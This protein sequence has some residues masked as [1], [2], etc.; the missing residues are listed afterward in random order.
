M[1]LTHLIKKIQASVAL[2]AC[3]SGL[4]AFSCQNRMEQTGKLLSYNGWYEG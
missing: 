4:I 1:K 3:V 2:F